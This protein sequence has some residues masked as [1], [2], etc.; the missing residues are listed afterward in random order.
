MMSPDSLFSRWI[1]IILWAALLALGGAWLTR[2]LRVDA[3]LRLGNVVQPKPGLRLAL[4][5]RF[6]GVILAERASLRA[7]ILVSWPGAHGTGIGWRANNAL[8]AWSE[9][10]FA[11]EAAMIAP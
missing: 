10:I 8:R 9:A 7:A 1:L 5:Q 11:A 4:E 2:S 6:H 3:D